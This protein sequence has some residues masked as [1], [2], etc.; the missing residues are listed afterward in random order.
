[1]AMDDD[2]AKMLK[3][4]LDKNKKEW[5]EEPDE[6]APLHELRSPEGHTPTYQMLTVLD[7]HVQSLIRITVSMNSKSKPPDIHQ[8]PRPFTAYDNL[9]LHSQR[10]NTQRLAAK[11]GIGQGSR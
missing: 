10:T 3:E 8:H 4:R 6:D 11:F 7:E 1:M 2:F 5:D 9:E